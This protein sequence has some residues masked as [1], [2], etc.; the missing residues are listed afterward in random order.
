[1]ENHEEEH[2]HH[3]HSSHNKSTGAKIWRWAEILLTAVQG[4]VSLLLI[5][6]LINTG[7]VAVWLMIILI[8]LLAGLL[9]LNIWML[10]IKKHS[11]KA[12]KIIC[13]IIAALIVIGGIFALRYTDAFNS[14]LN[15]ITKLNAE[16]KGYSVVVMD[17]SEINDLQELSGKSMGFLK[18]D[19][20]SAKAEQYLQ[21]KVQFEADYYDDLDTMMSALSKNITD[22]VVLETDRLEML[23]EEV[24]E[25]MAKT[26]VIYTFEIEIDQELEA[27][28]KEVTKDP[29]I[30]YISGSDSRTGIKTT[31]RS[32][33][34]ILAVVNPKQG[35][36]LLV[37]IPRDTYVQLHNT[38]G[39]KDKLTHA[40]VY[41]IDMSKK[42]IEDFLDTKIDHT[43]KVSF[44]TVVKV[45]DQLDGIDIT[46]DQAMTLKTNGKTCEF[47][48]GTQHVDGDCALRFA[49][50]R[51][52]YKTGDRH[53]GENQQQV[54]T[55]IINRL[56]GSKDYV[57]KLPT[58][59]DIAADSFETSL[60]RDDITSFIRMQLADS[61]DWQVESIAVDG[62]GTMEPTYSMGANRP[63]Y[64]M[65]PSEDSVKNAKEKI[66]EYLQSE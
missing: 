21:N 19:E 49:R 8:I 48:E 32:D 20:Q 64:V 3:H 38:T 33:V 52:K 42:T 10:F 37:S 62:T 36:I 14:F 51:K 25:E 39:L 6:S 16:T 7:I 15:K 40:G 11:S 41:G 63:L 66:D 24:E 47:I 26:R 12:M 46:S 57:L 5:I 61:I 18:I 29:F 31:A 65:I 23:K 9:A 30:T 54:I 34:N 60:S 59:L 55:S 53:R 28:A 58:I 1:M 50:E 43:L 35:K 4:I 45:V 44:D 13:P 2:H 27:S 56:S 17:E 22:A